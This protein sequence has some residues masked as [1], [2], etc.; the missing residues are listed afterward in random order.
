MPAAKVFRINRHFE[1]LSGSVDVLSRLT[2]FTN[3]NLKAVIKCH[4]IFTCQTAL[5]WV[6]PVSEMPGKLRKVLLSTR[7]NIPRNDTPATECHW[8]AYLASGL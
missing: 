4:I 2:D 5:P 1:K 8:T 6:W 3:G 7:V